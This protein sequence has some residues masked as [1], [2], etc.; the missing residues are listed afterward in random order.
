MKNLNE[1][2]AK[3]QVSGKTLDVVFG[4]IKAFE[5]KLEVLKRECR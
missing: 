1:L 3:L 2:N 4:Y 5:M